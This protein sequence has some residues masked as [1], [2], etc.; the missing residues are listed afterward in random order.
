MK[1]I[2]KP[3]SDID[4][5]LSMQSNLD[6]SKEIKLHELISGSAQSVGRQ[7]DHNEDALFSL[8]TTLSSN[9]GRIPFGFYVIADGMGGHEYGEIASE[10]ATLTMIEQVAQKFFNQLF[11][12]KEQSP[13]GPVREILVNAVQN[14]H[15]GILENAPG[16]GTTLTTVIIWDNQ[17]AI[18]HVGDSRAYSIS[19]S[20]EVKALTRDHSLV[21]RLVELGQITADEAAVHPQ[22]NVLYRALGQGEPFEPDIITSPAPKSGW[23]LI[24]SDG[25][26]GVISEQEISEITLSAATPKEACQLM[27]NAANAA[28][29]PDNISAILVKI[30]G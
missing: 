4:D 5:N 14:C 19:P 30:P 7:R 21:S 25:L 29:G 27:V 9:R 20:G 10:I 18:A 12:L 13:S 3:K 16:G 24:C 26:W 1:K 8:T 28:G 15:E 23:L 11:T 6:D 2:V 17:M 22:R